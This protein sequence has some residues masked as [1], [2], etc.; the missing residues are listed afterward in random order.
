MR[1]EILGPL[2]VVD[3]GVSSFI[4]A[5]KAEILLVALLV[6]ADEVLATDQLITEIWGDRAPRR[7]TAGLHVYVSDLR[8]FL[9][10]AGRPDRSIVTMPP[11]YLLRMGS[12]QLDA[13]EFVRLM[14]L[15][16]GHAKQHHHQEASECFE[17]ALS[18]WRGPVPGDISGPIV[19][20][21]FT[22]LGEAHLECTE[23]LVESQLRLGR[24]R[25]LVGH[26]FSLTSEHPLRETFYRQLML[27]LYRSERKADALSVY[28]SARRALDSALGLEPCRRLQEIQRA[29]LVGDDQLLDARVAA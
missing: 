6:R 15:G 28:Q 3:H 25:E 1:Y 16:R 27:A 21:Y 14:N 9:K 17:G 23:R 22:W 2:R 26:L 7:A 24:H 11:G 13:L 12:D 20:G 29:I 19:G 5:R 18:L 4:G 10:R 8:K